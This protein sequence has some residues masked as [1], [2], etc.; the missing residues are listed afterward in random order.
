MSTFSGRFITGKATCWNGSLEVGTQ[1]QR[2]ADE[3]NQKR[4]EATKKQP[5]NEDG[6]KLAEKQVA[7]HS[8]PLPDEDSHPE[9]Q[10]KASASKTNSGA[11]KRGDTRTSVTLPDLGSV[12]LG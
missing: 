11:V 8:V 10:A 1:R 4:S 3:A 2:I 12:A 9:R 7:G 5:R 6:T